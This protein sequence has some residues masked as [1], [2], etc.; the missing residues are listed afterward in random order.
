MPWPMIGMGMIWQTYSRLVAVKCQ[1]S[2][3]GTIVYDAVW[4]VP[5]GEPIAN[6][7]QWNTD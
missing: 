4:R 3:V 7:S 6:P 1:Q 2:F 5:T